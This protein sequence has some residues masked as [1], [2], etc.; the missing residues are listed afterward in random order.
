MTEFIKQG[1]LYVPKPNPP[2]VEVYVDETYLNRNSGFLQSALILPGSLYLRELRSRSAKF[3]G[4]IQANTKEFKGANITKR[5]YSIYRDFLAD[6]V[7][8]VTQLADISSFR[9]IVSVDAFDRYLSSPHVNNIQTALRQSFAK[10]G[11]N[12]SAK[13]Q[14]EFSR[15]LYWLI[16][17]LPGIVQVEIPE[18]HFQFI[19]DNKH[20]YAREANNVTGAQSSLGVGLIIKVREALQIAANALIPRLVPQLKNCRVIAIDFVDSKHNFAIQA[21]D[22]ICHSFYNTI[23]E[24]HGY[25]DPSVTLKAQLLREFA[26][27]VN[28]SGLKKHTQLVVLKSGAVEVECTNA[29]LTSHVTLG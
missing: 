6:Y 20:Q 3:L 22:L 17:H 4:Q 23:K 12:C 29:H 1:E 11:L 7:S 26:S 28:L 25:S 2:S 14:K 10:L 27:S 21:A 15:Q 18:C 19:F 16:W 5:H 9:S 24:L 13:L 8:G